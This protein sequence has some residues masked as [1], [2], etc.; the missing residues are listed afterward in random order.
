MLEVN[1]LIGFGAGGGGA[2][3]HWR[4]A[5][6]P[7]SGA[8]YVQAME[9]EL[10]ESIG[11]LDACSGGTASASSVYLTYSADNAFDN[12][13]ASSW[14]ST[15]TGSGWLAYTF[16]APIEIKQIMWQ[17]DAS[18]TNNPTSITL[19]RSFDNGASWEDVAHFGALIW[20]PYEQKVLTA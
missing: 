16:S 17:I 8:N 2:A 18:L 11:G 20:T 15:S 19:Q 6:G 14:I 13:S 9:A 1:N 5:Y 12:N 7:S 3:T 10:R 4:L